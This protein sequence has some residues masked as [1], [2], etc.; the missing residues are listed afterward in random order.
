[1][2]HALWLSP[3]VP[4]HLRHRKGQADG[5]R[6]LPRTKWFVDLLEQHGLS[7]TLAETHARGK[8]E[9]QLAAL[10][11]VSPGL[12]G[13]GPLTR[14][15]KECDLQRW[16]YDFADDA[17]TLNICQVAACKSP[18]DTLHRLGRPRAAGHGMNMNRNHLADDKLLFFHIG[19]I[20]CRLA[21]SC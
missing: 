19:W 15:S 11:L 6:H 9:P 13:D 16:F 10:L 12:C 18:V 7:H 2:V 21:Q 20:T 14:W 5:S 8:R 3:F 17:Y 4:G 1:M